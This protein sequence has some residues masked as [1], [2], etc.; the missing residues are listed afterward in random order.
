MCFAA[1][2]HPQKANT[3]PLHPHLTCNQL[4]ITCSPAQKGQRGFLG[5]AAV[6]LFSIGSK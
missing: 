2:S 5:P 3:P 6:S 1:L 4:Q